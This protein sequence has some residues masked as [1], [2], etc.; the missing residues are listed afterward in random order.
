MASHRERLWIM[1][2][3]E[4]GI[5]RL[6]VIGAHTEIEAHCKAGIILR[7]NRSLWFDSLQEG[8]AYLDLYTGEQLNDERTSMTIYEP[9]YYAE[10]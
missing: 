8:A 9:S 5:L 7:K 10:P 3:F 1:G 4:R 2:G 6:F